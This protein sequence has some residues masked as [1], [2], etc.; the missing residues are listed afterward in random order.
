M[1]RNRYEVT[2]AGGE[3]VVV[4][5]PEGALGSEIYQLAIDKNKADQEAIKNRPG[6]WDAAAYALEDASK[7]LWYGLKSELGV[8]DAEQV[9]PRDAEVHRAKPLH[10]SGFVVVARIEH[11][12]IGQA[13]A[14]RGN[15]QR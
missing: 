6:P 2:L 12:E 1:A 8:G 14:Q 4:E 5:A 15:Q 3:K 10:H 9:V 7:G 11:R 13:A